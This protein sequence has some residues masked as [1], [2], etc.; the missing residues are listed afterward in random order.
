MYTNESE[1]KTS[2]EVLIDSLARPLG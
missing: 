2:Y 1:Q